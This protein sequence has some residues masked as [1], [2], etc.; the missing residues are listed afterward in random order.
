M[1]RTLRRPI[2]VMAAIVI[3]AMWFAAAAQAQTVCGKRADMVDQAAEKY[4]EIR[5]GGGL[6]GAQAIIELY[7]SEETGTWTIFQTTPN[8]LTCLMAAGESW[9][10]DAAGLTPTGDPA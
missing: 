6:V 5:R 7:V 1:T 3:A 10:D 2:F 8:G 9:Q 4:G